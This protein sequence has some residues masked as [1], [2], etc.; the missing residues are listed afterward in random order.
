MQLF[1]G[2]LFLNII[3]KQTQIYV[4]VNCMYSRGLIN[5]VKNIQTTNNFHLTL[6]IGSTITDSF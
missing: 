3:F 5:I 4:D 6:Y 2:K 1:N